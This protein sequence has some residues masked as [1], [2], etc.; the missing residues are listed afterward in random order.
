MLIKMFYTITEFAKEIG[1]SPQTL[2][3]WDKKGILKPHHV[4]MGGRRMYTNEQIDDYFRKSAIE[5]FPVLKKTDL[6]ILVLVDKNTAVFNENNV[7]KLLVDHYNLEDD[8]N[9]IFSYEEFYND[10]AVI[11]KADVRKAFFRRILNSNVSKAVIVDCN[12]L[13]SNLDWFY[14]N[15]IAEKSLTI[16]ENQN[17]SFNFETADWQIDYGTIR[18]V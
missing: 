6:L 7:R 8:S 5:S 10:K 18:I 2:R 15:L 13:L 1:V 9:I 17:I 11:A 14:I 12:G 3:I 4:G 16:I